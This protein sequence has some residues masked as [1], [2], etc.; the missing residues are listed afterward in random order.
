MNK[1]SVEALAFVKQLS[2][3]LE[4]YKFRTCSVAIAPPIIHLPLLHQVSDHFDLVSQNIAFEN[5]GAYTGEI[6]AFMLDEYVNYTLIGHSERRLYF[7]DTD[8]NLFKKL[9][10]AFKY[11]LKPIFCFGENKKERDAGNYLSS[12]KY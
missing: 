10:L 1:T 6:S 4:K 8:Q 3:F 2:S 9:L 12:I 7:N 11:D 5:K